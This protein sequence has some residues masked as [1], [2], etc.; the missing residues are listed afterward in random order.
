MT[1]Y[2][3]DILLCELLFLYVK[4]TYQKKVMKRLIILE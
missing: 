4:R 2:F 1:F 3:I